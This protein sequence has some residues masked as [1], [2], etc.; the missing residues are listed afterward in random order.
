MAHHSQTIIRD[1]TPRTVRPA[2]T[3]TAEAKSTLSCIVRVLSHWIWRESMPL[4]CGGPDWL[5]RRPAG[6][7]TEVGPRWPFSRRCLTEVGPRWPF[8]RWCLIE[9]VR[10]ALCVLTLTG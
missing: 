8:S 3:T 1:K 7:L 10:D 6:C 5:R 4:T 9:G 2:S